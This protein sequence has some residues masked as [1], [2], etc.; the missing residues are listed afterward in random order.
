MRDVWM[1]MMGDLKISGV[2]EMEMKAGYGEVLK[3][4]RRHKQRCNDQIKTWRDEK[5][6]YRRLDHPY[7]HTCCPRYSQ[8]TGGVWFQKWTAFK[9]EKGTS[10][11][12]NL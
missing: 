6:R 8:I 3:V 9:K 1:V 7:L 5:D 4:E 12:T 2:E 11:C 10:S